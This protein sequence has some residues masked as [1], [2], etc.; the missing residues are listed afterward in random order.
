MAKNINIYVGSIQ[1]LSADNIGLVNGNISFSVN[2][3]TIDTNALF[4]VSLGRYIN[5]EYDCLLPYEW[6]ATEYMFNIIKKREDQLK[7]ILLSDNEELIKKTVSAVQQN[8]SCIFFEPKQIKQF[9]CI[10]KKEFHT[11]V[12]SRRK[13]LNERLASK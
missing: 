7:E 2:R 12:K 5:M 8:S 6:E 10:P 3:E 11:L 4:Y 9:D 13:R 1:K